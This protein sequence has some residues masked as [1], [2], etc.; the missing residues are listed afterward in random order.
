ML[1]IN[2]Y[3]AGEIHSQWREYI[4]D[5]SID[6][7]LPIQFFSPITDH[8][9]SDAIGGQVFGGEQKEFWND[10]ISAKINSIRIQ[11]G[12]GRAD[13]VVVKFG[14]KYKQWNAAFDAGYAVAMN[15]PIIALHPEEFDHALKEIDGHAR[16]VARTESQVVAILEY[17]CT[18]Q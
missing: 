16:A 12:I 6:K 10:H 17:V 5:A 4:I 1:P 15:I 18:Q 7:K 8:P 3:L 14:E 11:T 2:V 9:K 13:V